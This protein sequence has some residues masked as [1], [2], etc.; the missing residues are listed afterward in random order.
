[1]PTP[2]GAS[3]RSPPDLPAG[4]EKSPLEAPPGTGHPAVFPGAPYTDGEAAGTAMPVAH[5]PPCSH[6]EHHGGGSHPA[7]P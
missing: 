4:G 2:G 5:V 1:M 7:V 3:L 6:D